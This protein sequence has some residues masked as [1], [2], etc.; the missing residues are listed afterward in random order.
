M[1]SRAITT[2]G[3]SGAGLTY[4]TT[5]VSKGPVSEVAEAVTP[6]GTIDPSTIWYSLFPEYIDSGAL[7]QL[8][9]KFFFEGIMVSDIVSISVGVISGVV[10]LAR[11]LGD[12]MVILHKRKLA[13]IELEA[14][15]EK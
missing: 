10:L 12:G 5:T 8:D 1:S 7:T 15:K 9:G 3:I 11:L 4:S 13:K 2:Y 14:T 6:V